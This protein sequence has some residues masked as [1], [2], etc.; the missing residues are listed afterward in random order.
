MI[1]RAMNCQTCDEL[2]TDYKDA[3]RLLKNAV[4]YGEVAPV[5]DNLLAARRDAYLLAAGRAV[6]WGRICKYASDAHR[7][8]ATGT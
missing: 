1:S 8:L 7:A 3:V 6:H 4:H 5:R 2:L